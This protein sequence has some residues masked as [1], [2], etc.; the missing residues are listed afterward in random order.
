MALGAVALASGPLALVAWNQGFGR[1]GFSTPIGGEKWF[2]T[3]PGFFEAKGVKDP[4]L[5]P[6]GRVFNWTDNEATL[7]FPR[8]ERSRPA[9]ITLRIQGMGSSPKETHEV[10]FSVDG[11][12]TERLAI[13]T[14]PKRVPLDIP[15][16]GGRGALVSIKVLGSVGVMVENVRLAPGG[17]ST[18]PI[19]GEALGALALVSLAC[20][21]AAL[22]AGVSPWVALG[23]ALVEAGTLSWL[24][25]TGGAFLGRYSERISWL[26]VI[27]LLLS[28]G[29]TRVRNP[30][31]RLAATTVLWIATLKLSLLG[32]PQIIDADA[33]GHAANLRRVVAG[34]WF[35]TS[36]TP[37]PAISFPYPPGLYAV[38]LPLSSLPQTEWV[39]LLRGIV[40][41]TETL[42]TLAFALA[43]ARMSTDAVGAL[44]FVLLALSPEGF[45]VF[46]I[47]NLSNLFSDSLMI[48]GC[49]F[50]LVGRPVLASLALWG[51][52][53]SHFGTLLLGPPLSFL[54][55][56]VRGEGGSVLRRAAP[57][58]AA[59]LASF[60]L[61][62]RRFMNVVIEGWDRMRHLEGAAAVGPM[63][64]PVTEKLA[65]MSGG[66]SW[67]ITAV[68]MLALAI[69][70]ATWPQERKALA[71]ALG[72]WILVIA[73]FAF[74]GLV[75]PVQVRVALAARPAMAALCASGIAALWTR[76]GKAR[77]L[78][79]LI[80][81]LT[82][83][84]C[85]TIAISFLPVKPV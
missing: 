5:S 27:G 20:Y 76:G 45:V 62:Y 52:F 51:G 55:A 75:T 40:V 56:W 10:V 57:L 4:E 74:V 83:I 41:V 24:S 38:A 29:M 1:G 37:P 79:C 11:V 26:A 15:P 43:V 64:A 16:R 42:A 28:A 84:A 18:V 73:A 60:L 36:A 8:L 9:T 70:V 19:P 22:G 14:A 31:W 78:A 34:D 49:A 59:L 23:A 82:A 25:I 54:L 65:R 66:E 77:S 72:A 30:R 48:F 67:W 47:G 44:T 50:L 6:T 7:R 33:A 35:F 63:T 21:L 85:W 2:A 61:Y 17:G 46:F 13:P 58:I 3:R 69:G 81:G 12:E 68:L 80:V 53:L 39:T 32:H 71:R